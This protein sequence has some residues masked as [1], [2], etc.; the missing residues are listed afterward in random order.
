MK[1]SEILSLDCSKK[2]NIEIIKKILYKIFNEE[3]VKINKL[4]KYIFE[5]YQSKTNTLSMSIY[6]NSDDGNY[7]SMYFKEKVIRA[8]S[9]YEL[10]SKATI[11]IYSKGN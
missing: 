4:E 1:T 7:Y 6:N 10:F 8:K 11:Y 2:E 3:N 9:I 5:N